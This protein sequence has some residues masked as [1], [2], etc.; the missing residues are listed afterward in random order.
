MTMVD[1]AALKAV[2]SSAAQQF[3]H[4]GSDGPEPRVHGCF[5]EG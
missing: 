3:C 4:Q 1:K 2:L 5:P